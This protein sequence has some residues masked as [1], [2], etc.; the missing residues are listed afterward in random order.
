MIFYRNV[1]D[2]LKSLIRKIQVVAKP[3]AVAMLLI[4]LQT[5]AAAKTVS[6]TIAVQ[7]KSISG[8]V[9]DEQGIG[10]PG[11]VV[12]VK[13]T[14]RS[15]AAADDGTYKITVPSNEAVLVFSYM[16]MSA[17]EQSVKGRNVI[18]VTL[19]AAAISMQDVVIVGYGTSKRSDLTSAQTTISAK[20]I[21]R[22]V[23][24]TVEQAIQGRSAGV[25]ITQ[26]SGQP[27]GG[28]SVNIRGVNSINGTNEPLYVIDG[29][30]IQGQSVG[31]GE[32]ASTNPL[33]ALNPS[34]I[35]DIQV[36][37]G[38][39][40]TAIYGSRATNG[41][42]LI[43]TKRGKAG[44]SKIGFNSN[45]T[46]QTGPK[47]LDVMNLQQ[48][49]QMLNEYSAVFNKTVPAALRDPSLLGEGTNWQKEL[50]QNSP[51]HKH[52]LSL[53]GGNDKTTYYLSGEYMDQQGVAAG[54]GFKRYGS[55]L[56]VDSKPRTWLSMG[57]NL[58]FTQTD[59][60]LS[61]SQENIIVNA[62]RLTPQIPVKNLDGSWG[63][64]DL[65]NGA[66]QFAP[67]N[68]LAIAAI[69]TNALIRKQFI[70][71]VNLGVNIIEGLQF[72]TSFNTNFGF[73]NSNYY[74]PAYKI[75][76]AENAF[77]SLQARANQNYYWGWNQLLEY[78]KKLGKHSLN[79]MASHEAQASGYRNL[80]GYRQGF[81]TDNIIDLESG[82][83]LTATA[84]GGSG[85]WAM[86][87]YLG[88]INYNFDNRYIVSATVRTDGSANFGEN[89]KWGVFPSVSAAWRISQEKFFNV[90]QISE[91]K[92]R[93]ELGTTGNQ[94]SAGYIYSPM[95][96]GATPTGT[97]FLP[98]RYG[99]DNLQWEETFTKNIGINIGLFR[100]RI[101]LEAD[102]YI[103]DTDNLLMENP[104][105]WYMG[106]NG[107]GSVAAPY[108]NIGA[109]QNKGWG[110]TL[111][112]VNIS[113]K[114]FQW[115]SNF[116]I[117]G[118]KTTIKKFYSDKAQVDRVSPFME[119]WTQRSVVGKA[120]W[121]FLGYV[122][123]GL[124]R[125]IYEIQYAALPVDNNGQK[126]IIDQDYIW[127]GDIRFKDVSGP[128]GVPDGVIDSYDLTFIGNPY[129]KFYLGFTNSFTYKAF[130]MSI[131]VTGVYGN[132]VY[133][134][135]RRITSNVDNPNNSRNMMVDGLNYAR[136]TADANGYPVLANPDTNIPRISLGPNNNYLRHTTRWVEDGS[137]LRVKNITLGYNLPKTL[138]N[139]LKVVQ[140]LRVAVS[141]QN[142]FTL[143]RYSG[144]DPE[145][146]S[147][148]GNQASQSNQAIGV[149]YNRYP[150]TRIYSFSLGASF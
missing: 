68:P 74:R 42:L 31:S 104:L 55:R 58:A 67:V 21:E 133:N 127:V 84:N 5:A 98:R 102:Y 121:Q 32:Q 19:K 124:F 86:E 22:T 110:V 47:Q 72:R 20:D 80:S 129:P 25:Y 89:N 77:S 30:Q 95:G 128:N 57:A 48:Y 87:S 138:I 39:S 63:G 120:P 126:L 9:I 119:S 117:S 82:D 4:S 7:E 111:N 90:K 101:E 6:N 49:A 144:Y 81:L 83:P 140:S 52:Q 66:N 27:G 24:T 109:L 71:G 142:L 40:A 114:N 92:L 23:N 64:G 131:M 139:R 91:L 28:I 29:V 54:S 45:Y 65:D 12:T 15:V 107:A 70:G 135:S 99:N 103:K 38:P 36:L 69:T 116:N 113:N 8:K 93:L 97:G 141:G 148:V 51:M 10:I 53:S 43:T 73:T 100:N 123:Q 50:F 59:E 14:T 122:E 34:D 33:A 13:G 146:G 56:N 44:Q 145:V 134:Y 18:N 94:G 137:F 41:V 96:T 132:D 17:V 35:E 11:A 37:Q 46:L 118:F 62:L 2:C 106:T 79:V 115:R 78:N 76:W 61:T 88:R 85:Q 136:P 112:T 150:L 16:G 75:G 26:N 143:T 125:N 147:Y 149:D 108:V 3:M 1:K 130:D 60:A 105:P